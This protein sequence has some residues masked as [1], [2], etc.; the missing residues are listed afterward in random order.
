MC[1]VPSGPGQGDAAVSAWAVCEIA[2][3]ESRRT[4]AL[5]TDPLSRNS[6]FLVQQVPPG[7]MRGVPKKC[8]CEERARPRVP[9]RG[10][11]S[12]EA[13]SVLPRARLLRCGFSWGRVV[14]WPAR[15]DCHR[16]CPCCH[17]GSGTRNDCAAEDETHP[18]GV[19]SGPA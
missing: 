1:P 14:S 4:D 10:N 3:L 5:R 7:G 17:A 16:S 8:H 2:S 18:I 11:H 15:N 19:I 9:L 12:D 6:R 13:I